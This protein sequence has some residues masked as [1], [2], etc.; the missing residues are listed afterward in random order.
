MSSAVPDIM[1]NLASLQFE[2]GLTEDEKSLVHL[3]DHAI[4]LTISTSVHA[5]FFCRLLSTVRQKIT[6]GNA[7]L[8]TKVSKLWSPASS[9]NSIKV[10]IIGG[11]H[12]GK[13]LARVLLDVTDVPAA[14]IRISSRRPETLHEFQKV[15]IECFYNNGHL[16][17][18]SDVLFL[19]CLPAHLSKIC[20]EIKGR[21]SESCIVYSLITAVP[22]PRLKQLL[23]HSAI[24]RPE[25]VFTGGYTGDIWKKGRTVSAALKDSAVIKATWPYSPS[26]GTLVKVKWYEA[27][28]YCA[29]NLCTSNKLSH[30]QSVQLLNEILLHPFTSEETEMTP[31]KFVPESFVNKSFCA[32]MSVEDFFPSFDLSAVQ[33][34][35]TPLSRFLEGNP[36]LLEQLCKVYCASFGAIHTESKVALSS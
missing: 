1:A 30:S 20:S 36:T 3:R 6:T 18:S 7:S 21:L 13:Q 29:L 27:V 5:A 28:L 33:G 15:G 34:K 31:S 19:C 14:H 32:T 22:I 16:A 9:N 12:I 23:C 25:Y 17:A 11:G 24:L 2:H 8:T 10:G 35:D 4:A 26:E